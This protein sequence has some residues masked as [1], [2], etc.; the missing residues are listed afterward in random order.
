M[1]H[2][3]RWSID[4]QGFGT[5]TARGHGTPKTR[6]FKDFRAPAPNLSWNSIGFAQAGRPQLPPISEYD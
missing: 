2:I 6:Q 5:C 3:H 4:D 1:N